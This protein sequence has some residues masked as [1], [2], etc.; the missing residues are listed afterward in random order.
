M[1]TTKIYHDKCLGERETIRMDNKVMLAFIESNECQKEDIVYSNSL[2][3]NNWNSFRRY[4][5]Y[6]LLH[7]SQNAAR[8]W[9]IDVKIG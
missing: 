7:K 1:S 6:I 2:F 9:R 3:R 4:N 8:N 5:G